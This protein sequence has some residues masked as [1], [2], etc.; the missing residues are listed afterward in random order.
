MLMD[1]HDVVAV[2]LERHRLGSGT[3]AV[4]PSWRMLEASVS[5]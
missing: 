5:L 3:E 1:R 4:T 2:A